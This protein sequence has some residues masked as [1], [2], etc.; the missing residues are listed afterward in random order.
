MARFVIR[1]ILL[2]PLIGACGS[3]DGPKNEL[4][5]GALVPRTGSNANAD[6]IVAEQLAVDELNQALGMAA[7]PKN[8]AIRWESRDTASTPAL[9]RQYS[10]ELVGLGAKIL[11][12]EASASAH[13]NAENYA[14]AAP[15]Q[16]ALICASCTSGDIN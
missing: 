5:I 10:R 16:T 4:L 6:W 1:A 8:L 9:M 7:N 12:A 13:A 15:L 3:D 14:A 2:L 11:T